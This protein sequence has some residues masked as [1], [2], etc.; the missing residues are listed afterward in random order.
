MYTGTQANA[1]T[2]VAENDGADGLDLQSRVTLSV[3]AGTAYWLRVAGFDGS[4]GSIVLNWNLEEEAEEVSHKHIFPQFPFGGG[5]E[6]TL[7]LQA[8]D[9]DTTCTFSAQDRFLTMQRSSG[10]TYTGTE[11]SFFLP[12]MNDWRILKTATPQGSVVSSGMAVLDCNKEVSANTLFSLEVGGSV[13]AE[14][15]GACRELA[16]SK[17]ESTTYEPS[18]VCKLLIL[19]CRLLIPDRL[20]ARIFHQ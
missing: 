17:Q 11:L 19:G 15:L 16:P 6:S 7:M 2:L 1:L 3:T 5:W 8:L 9:G 10:E 13:V 14:A 4:E 12:G 18:L 20:L